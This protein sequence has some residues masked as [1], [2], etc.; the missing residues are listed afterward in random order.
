M[1]LDLDRDGAFVGRRGDREATAIEALVEKAHPGAVVEEDLQCVAATTEEHD[2]GPRPRI[3]TDALESH[4][5]ETVEAPPKVDRFET[6]EHL[7]AVRDHAAPPFAA[8]RA[9]AMS[10][11]SRRSV[12]S[13]DG[14]WTL[15]EPASI[16]IGEDAADP[17]DSGAGARCGASDRARERTTRAIRGVLVERTG[18]A[19]PSFFTQY[20]NAD[21]VNPFPR[22]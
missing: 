19:S 18:C 6:D 1:L 9:R 20:P 17:S 8:A 2:Q 15:T 13:V 5:R 3:S 21:R 12:A 22:Q 14:T 10:T 16:T 11:D 7:D 4:V